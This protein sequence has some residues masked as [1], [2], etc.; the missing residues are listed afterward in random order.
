VSDPISPMLATSGQPPTGPGWGWEFKWDGQRGGAALTNGQLVLRARPQTSGSFGSNIT[1]TYPELTELIERVNGRSMILDG[2]I[3]ALVDGQPSFNALQH[4]MGARPTKYRCE[5]YPV[6]YHVFDLLSLD[7]QRVM[8]HPYT[9]RRALLDELGFPT[10]Y[11]GD[12]RIVVPPYMTDVNGM[13]LLGV[14]REHGLEGIVAKRLISIYQPGVWSPHWVKTR[15][16][17]WSPRK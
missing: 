15:V 1:N 7:G 8:D 12:T 2:E 11:S 14:A 10:C 3:V 9:V 17:E 4:R 16:Q 5:K 6:Y 13:D